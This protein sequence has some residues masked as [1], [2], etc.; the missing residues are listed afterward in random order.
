LKQIT[1]FSETDTV[2]KITFVNEAFCL[3][4]GYEKDELINRPHSII[5]HGDMPAELFELLWTTIARGMIFRGII[6]NKKKD[7]THYWVR[8]TIMPIQSREMEV[9]KY[10][11]VRHLI[12][13]E[14]TAT[15]LYAQ[16]MKELKL[17]R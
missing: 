5:R 8:A 12:E 10:V 16:Q 14:G 13:D 3:V 9:V 6:K 11:G 7:N 17:P 1:L 15:A 2:G 4:T